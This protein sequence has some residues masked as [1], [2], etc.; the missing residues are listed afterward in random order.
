MPGETEAKRT[1][2][3]TIGLGLGL[4]GLTLLVYA[5]ALEAG[6]VWDDDANVTRNLPLRSLAGLRALWLEPGATTQYYP[7]VY[8]SFWIEHALVGFEPLLYHL[9]NVL[10]HAGVAVLLWRLLVLMGLPGAWLAAAV[11]ALHPVHV[12][13]V[14]WVTERKNVLSGFFYLASALVYLRWASDAF[15]G[16]MPTPTPTQRRAAYAAA[17]GLFLAALLSKSPTASLP[18][19][20]G[21]VIW[22]KKGRLTR[23][24]WLPL[25][26]FALIAV[27]I[28]VVTTLLEK[29]VGTYLG[30]DWQPSLIERALLAGRALV[31]YASKLLWPSQLTFVY[32]RWDIDAG[33]LLAWVF[34]LVAAG[35]GL[36]A[37]IA[38]ER[39]GRGPATALFF[40]AGTLLPVLGL[41]EIYFFRFSFVADHW[42]YLA[43]I[44]LI[45]GLVCGAAG[46]LRGRGRG[47][48]VAAAALLC[49]LGALTWQQARIYVDSETLWR[50][51]LSKNPR[52]AMVH[53]NLAHELAASG[54]TREASDHYRRVIE[55]DPSSP[56]A[57]N[58]LAMLRV[59]EGRDREALELLREATHQAPDYARGRWN[60]GLFLARRGQLD[61]ALPHFDHALRQP[62]LLEADIAR[63]AGSHLQLARLLA[64]HGRLGSARQ[65]TLRALRTEPDSLPGWLQLG[66]LSLREQDFAAAAEAFE[67]ALVLAPDH[68][69]A[70]AGLRS[71]RALGGRQ[72]APRLLQGAPTGL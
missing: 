69:P 61:A 72:L 46:G 23:A 1:R 56:N 66:R 52:S 63:V 62:I 71:A 10:L 42:Q 5:P 47:P 9:D 28:G 26:P 3:H 70:R 67:R 13:S 37:F 25:V 36:G 39:L 65:H 45:V 18:A 27:P 2:A 34:P 40:F 16:S 31:F 48:A 58:N 8:T 12:E 24:D 29:N 32:P 54:R 55:L 59:A 19:A 57:Y 60:L 6:F 21:L 4:L 30:L 15:R 50:D 20:L 41:V 49:V 44:G 64:G 17:L 43:S 53:Y 68:A 22:W 14:A 33:Q 7:L 38:R 51:S 35:V 11:F